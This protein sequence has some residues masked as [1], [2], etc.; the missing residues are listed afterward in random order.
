MKMIASYTT[1]IIFVRKCEIVKALRDLI[2]SKC[3][4]QYIS[5]F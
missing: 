4:Q 3:A 5:R 2:N 1:E